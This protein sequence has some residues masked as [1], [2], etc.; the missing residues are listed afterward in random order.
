MLGEGI[1]SLGMELPACSLRNW[2]ASP[3]IVCSSE[4]RPSTCSDAGAHSMSPSAL[5]NLTFKLPSKTLVMP[6]SW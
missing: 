3:K 2:N 4:M 1:V 5:W 6:P